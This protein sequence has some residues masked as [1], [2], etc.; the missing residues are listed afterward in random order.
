MT[1][2]H[3]YEQCLVTN[4]EELGVC[5]C[6]IPVIMGCQIGTPLCLSHVAVS[7]PH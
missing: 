1:L 7:F 5:P 4:E 3:D 6:L 2:L